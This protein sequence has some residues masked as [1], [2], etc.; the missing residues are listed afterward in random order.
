MT[1]SRTSHSTVTGV[2]GTEDLSGEWANPLSNHLT[3]L[4]HNLQRLRHLMRSHL[5]S[6]DAKQAF[7]ISSSLDRTD[8]FA[9]AGMP[10]TPW[11]IGVK[12]CNH[13][14]NHQLTNYSDGQMWH[15]AWNV[16]SKLSFYPQDPWWIKSSTS[17]H[18][19]SE[20]L[21]L[22]SR[23]FL[24]YFQPLRIK[25]HPNWPSKKPAQN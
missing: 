7:C 5:K 23:W 17:R 11:R 19:R 8:A 18:V 15:C 1:Q 20:V 14:T 6:S 16:C 13:P 9:V 24:R 3:T 25:K 12:S 4:C 10:V 21:S 22:P 2:Y